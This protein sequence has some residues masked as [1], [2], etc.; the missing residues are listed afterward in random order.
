[1]KKILISGALFFLILI[2]N[3]GLAATSSDKCSAGA[4]KSNIAALFPTKFCSAGDL[5]SGVIKT[6]LALISMVAVVVIILGGYKYVTSN[7]NTESAGAAR[8]AITNAVIGLVVAVLAYTVVSVVNNTLI[9]TSPATSNSGGSDGGMGSG[10]TGSDRAAQQRAINHLISATNALSTE[11]SPAQRF[12]KF[13]VTVKADPN[14]IATLCPDH[15]ET[16]KVFSTIGVPLG[17]GADQVNIDYSSD[18]YGLNPNEAIPVTMH[19]TTESHPINKPIT[20]GGKLNISVEIDLDT[21]CQVIYDFSKPA[22]GI[23]SGI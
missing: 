16:A 4:V 2:P 23:D 14:D 6:L 1:M 10:G 17:E 19:F 13:D 7:G 9:S 20:Q 12:V 11:P 3:L 21:G 8:K 22:A 5:M 15:A 18:Q